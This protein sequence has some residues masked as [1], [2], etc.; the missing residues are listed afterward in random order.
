M[1]FIVAEEYEKAR[2]KAK[3]VT[4]IILKVTMLFHFGPKMHQLVF[5]LGHSRA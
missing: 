2:L 5:V 1:P 4:L 3:T